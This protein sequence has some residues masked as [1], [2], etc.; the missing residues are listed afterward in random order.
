MVETQIATGGGVDP[1]GGPPNEENLV[2][3]QYGE[4]E[5]NI[6]NKYLTETVSNL[7]TVNKDLL[8]Q[9]LHVPA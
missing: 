9:Q 5:I 6:L 3:V 4:A 8:N 2:A 1:D 7:L